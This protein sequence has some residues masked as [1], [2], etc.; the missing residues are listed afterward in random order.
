MFYDKNK[1]KL[2]TPAK[3]SCFQKILKTSLPEQY[4]WD[5]L[6]NGK[7]ELSKLVIEKS[8]FYITS[9]PCVRRHLPVSSRRQISKC[10]SGQ[11][12]RCSHVLVRLKTHGA[13]SRCKGAL[14]KEERHW[15]TISKHS[16]TPLQAGD[17]HECG[18]GAGMAASH[19]PPYL[20]AQRDTLFHLYS[21]AVHFHSCSRRVKF[22]VFCCLVS[23]SRRQISRHPHG[24][25]QKTIGRQRRKT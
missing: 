24:K 17:S 9:S 7:F 20:S 2:F 3:I 22:G 23:K 1:Q 16:V 18:R 10:G 13:N 6:G 25:P 15:V 4:N 8:I 21:L 14:T 11:L 19:C 12:R 5:P